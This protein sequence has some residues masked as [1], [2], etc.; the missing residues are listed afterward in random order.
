MIDTATN[1]LTTTIPVGTT[2]DGVAVSPDGA[3]AYVAD[4]SDGTVSVIDTATN[5]V[6][7]SIPLGSSLAGVA[8]SPDSARAYA[9]GVNSVSVIDTATN[10]IAAI[11]AISLTNNTPQNVA[12]SAHGTHV[13][14]TNYV[15]GT[16]SV[17]DTAT[18]TL[19]TTIAVGDGP[20]GVAVS[21]DDTHVYVTNSNDNTVS[22]ISIPDSPVFNSHSQDLIG[23]LIGAVDRDG[24][25]WLVI[26]NHVIPIP[27]QSPFLY[28]IARAAAPHL[29]QAI[30]NPKLADEIH[31]LLQAEPR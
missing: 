8:V 23:K 18:N 29:G 25:G 3:H 17:I 30:E 4:N 31:Q 5:T 12:V 2:P 19:T 28:A 20:V 10:T 27:P 13:Y 22:V 9:A 21:P 14:V 24:G 15:D 6:T 16:V 11:I 1:A 26:G 7:S